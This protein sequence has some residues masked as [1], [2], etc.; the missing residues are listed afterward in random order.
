MT[1]EIIYSAKKALIMT[2]HTNSQ[3]S[4]QP[5]L[6]NSQNFQICNLLLKIHF[7]LFEENPDTRQVKM[8]KCVANT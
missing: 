4:I 8:F 7:C 2:S 1:K 3:F 5:F 6:G